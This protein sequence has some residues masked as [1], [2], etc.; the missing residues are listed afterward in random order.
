MATRMSVDMK[1]TLGIAG[2]L[3]VIGGVLMGLA[4]SGTL[5]RP[6]IEGILGGVL[7]TVLSAAGTACL[8][9]AYRR[10][11]PTT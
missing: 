2:T 5:P 8:F 11:Q 6:P 1:V 7:P 3:L 4:L 9:F 10:P